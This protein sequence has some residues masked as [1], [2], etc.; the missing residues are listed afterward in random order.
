[1]ARAQRVTYLKCT[2][3]DQPGSLLAL[4][5]RLKEKNA[6][7]TGLWGA[8]SQPGQA[9]L[10]LLPK[11]TEK[12]QEA[13]K[14]SGTTFESGTG[15]LVK[16][17]DKTGA[18]LNTLDLIAKAGVNIVATGALALSGNYGVFVRVAPADVEKVAQ[19]LGT[20]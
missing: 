10:F 14:A 2:L 7:L 15:F 1:M 16:G 9:E 11:N 18:L 12:L 13:L 3:P 8:A 4:A 6:G 5:K 17:V 20:K 19:A